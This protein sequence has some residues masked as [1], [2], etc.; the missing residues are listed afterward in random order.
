MKEKKMQQTDTLLY[1]HENLKRRGGFER[2]PVSIDEKAT[3][4]RPDSGERVS[5][6]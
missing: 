1:R 3:G 2:A 4:K 6:N 5:P